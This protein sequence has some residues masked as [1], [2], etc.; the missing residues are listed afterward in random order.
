MVGTQSMIT[1]NVCNHFPNFY[2]AKLDTL[3]LN[4]LTVIAQHI[5]TFHHTPD[6][7]AYQI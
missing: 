2:I 4:I 1:Q 3:V 7:A 6:Q 5:L